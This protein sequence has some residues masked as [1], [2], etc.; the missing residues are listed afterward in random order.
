MKLLISGSSGYVGYV[1]S[2]YFSERGN[3]VIGLDVAENSAWSGNSNF[4]FYCCDVT[5]KKL[6][7]DILTKEKPTHVIHCAFLMKPLHDVKKNYEIDVTGSINIFQVAHATATVKQ[8]IE[9][10]ST[11]AYG[12]WPDNKLWIQETQ[13]LQPRDYRY[14]IHKKIVEEYYNTYATRKDFKLVIVRMCTAIGSLYHKKGGVVR[15]LVKA[16]LVTKINN[17]DCELQFIHEDDL[18][19]LIGLIVNDRTIEGTFNLA[20]DSYA[21]P[22][23]LMPDKLLIPIPLWFMRGIAA[24]GWFVRLSSMNASAITLSAYGIVADPHKL[25]KRYNYHFKYSTESGFKDTVEKRIA[26]G[27]L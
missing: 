24:I 10:S 7:E 26:K 6:L 19:A 22:K 1:L 5:N 13:K 2:K 25:M 16:P 8:F 23:S 12:A 9:F 14:G 17:R 11:S 4:K 18:T 3:E 20:P 27:T 15:L 21:T